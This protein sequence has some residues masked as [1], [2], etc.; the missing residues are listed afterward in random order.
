VLLL[1]WH[2]VESTDSWLSD[3]TD[4]S[5]LLEALHLLRPML[6]RNG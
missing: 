3:S 4:L 6:I 5:A 2:L 1:P